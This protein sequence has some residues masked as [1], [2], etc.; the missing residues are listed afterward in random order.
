ML[1]ELCLSRYFTLSTGFHELGLGL[2]CRRRDIQS[3]FE[4]A[5]WTGHVVNCQSRFSGIVDYVVVD[6]EE[7][8]ENSSVGLQPEDMDCSMTSC[9]PCECTLGESA[10]CSRSCPRVVYPNKFRRDVQHCVWPEHLP[11]LA[12]LSQTLCMG[13]LKRAIASLKSGER[14]E[15]G[16][17]R[18]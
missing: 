6:W 11:R 1:R 3:V 10:R 13:F 8:A 17:T 7:G 4:P 18:T 15:F 14:D 12:D 9:R 2:R 5:P 16:D